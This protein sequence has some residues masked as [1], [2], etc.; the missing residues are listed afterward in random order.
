MSCVQS[1][2]ILKMVFYIFYPLQVLAITVGVHLNLKY[3]ILYCTP[4]Y[5]ANENFLL[6]ASNMWIKHQNC[7]TL[8]TNFSKWT[9]A[10]CYFVENAINTI[11]VTQRELNDQRESSGRVFRLHAHPLPL[12]SVSWTGDTGRLRKRDN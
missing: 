11:T 3:I 7:A 4:H 12:P 10:M 9:F 2:M 1:L 6:L 5:K 8:S